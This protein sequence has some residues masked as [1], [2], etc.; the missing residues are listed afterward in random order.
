MFSTLLSLSDCSPNLEI[1][2]VCKLRFYTL[3]TVFF[4]NLEVPC[5]LQNSMD[6]LSIE[7][8]RIGIDQ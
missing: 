6:H 5:T 2:G 4:F 7:R 1:R 3:A 8:M